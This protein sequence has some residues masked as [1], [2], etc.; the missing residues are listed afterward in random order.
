MMEPNRI[1]APGALLLAAALL[2]SAGAAHAQ[3]KTIRWIVPFPPGGITDVLARAVSVRLQPALGQPVVVENRPGAGGMI[4]AELVAR[5]TPDGSLLIIAGTIIPTAPA[6]YAKLAFDPLKD[7]APVAH[8][9]YSANVLVV[10]ADHPAKS[11]KELV[12]MARR[13]PGRLNYA[14]IGNGSLLQLAAE[15]LKRDTGTFIVQIPYRGGGE[16]LAAVMTRQ[17]DF[18]FD[19]VVQQLPQIQGGKVRALAV[20][21]RARDAA[22]P[23]VPT[24]IESGFRDF[25][26]TTWTGVWTTGGTPAE[27]VARLEGE[28]RK[29][30]ASPELLA[31]AQKAGVTITNL[32]SR[33]LA[34]VVQQEAVKWDKVLK[35]AGV[36]PE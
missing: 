19:N 18:V 2:A 31:T 30:L 3:G 33:E 22:L 26:I 21:S 16:M 29:V 7:L 17:V 28:M 4:G 34:G 25:D 1:R 20:T 5:G 32:G 27:A 9:G 36:K 11:A 24:M 10:A 13:S 12:D 6:L 14:S 8:V 35:Y 15:Q 23:E